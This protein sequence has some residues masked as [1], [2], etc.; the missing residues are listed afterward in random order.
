MRGRAIGRGRSREPNAILDPRTMGSQP[1]PKADAQSPSQAGTPREPLVMKTLMSF[2]RA[3]PLCL[4]NL[5]MGPSSNINAMG[6][7]FQHKF[8][9][10]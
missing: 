7:G 4:N 6:I 5:P 9:L 8:V 1:E 3:P 10:I 2:V